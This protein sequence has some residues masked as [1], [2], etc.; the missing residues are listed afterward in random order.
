MIAAILG[1][2]GFTYAWW[3]SNG[4]VAV[5]SIA[6]GEL[7]LGQP[8]QT[9]VLKSAV[10]GEVF[11]ASSSTTSNDPAMN[12]GDLENLT[13]PCGDGLA[14]E[15]VDSYA[16]ERDGAN[17]DAEFEVTWRDGVEAESGGVGSFS[18]LDQAGGLLLGG[19]IGDQNG[20]QT[21]P[22]DATGLTVKLDYDM[23]ACDY[24]KRFGQ[25]PTIYGY[26]QLEVR[27]R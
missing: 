14:L 6:N 26:Y 24:G 21:L 2:S 15:V 22:G 11:A 19:T 12:V 10:S 23:P 5:G 8:V 16:V 9:W 1:G 13:T 25:D 18:V 7:A 20:G 4:S 3:T 17:M 27:Q